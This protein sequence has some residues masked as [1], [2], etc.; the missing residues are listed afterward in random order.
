MNLEH[1]AK[2]YE[3]FYKDVYS[4]D[5]LNTKIEES[6]F[7]LCAHVKITKERLCR[8]K[9]TLILDRIQNNDPIYGLIQFNVTAKCFQHKKGLSGFLE[10]AKGNGGIPNW[11]SGWCILTN[12]SICLWRCPEEENVTTPILEL[13][14]VESSI[15][16]KTGEKDEKSCLILNVGS[17]A[18]EEY[19]LALKSDEDIKLW[20]DMVRFVIRSYNTWKNLYVD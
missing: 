19:Y 13:N 12:T 18:S 6:A 4:G 3:I 20:E 15:E 17:Q 5:F 16:V 11:K 10:M 7:K 2:H 1:N 8:N 9:V 14:L